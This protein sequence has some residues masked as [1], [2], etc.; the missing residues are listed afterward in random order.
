MRAT[1]VPVRTEHFSD[2]RANSIQTNANDGIRAF[3]RLPFADAQTVSATF[4]AGQTLD[5][6]HGLQRAPSGAFLVGAEGGYGSWQWFPQNNTSTSVRIQS[7]NA[8]KFAW[9]VF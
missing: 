3:N 1:R 2:R 4:T 7:Q 9:V 6:P 8:G 5:L